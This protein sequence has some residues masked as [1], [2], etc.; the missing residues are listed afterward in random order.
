V[1]NLNTWLFYGCRHRQHDFLFEYFGFFTFVFI[2][3][4]IFREQIRNYQQINVL[5]H[6]FIA[7]SREENYPVSLSA[8][9]KI[10][11]TNT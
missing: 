5:K 3:Y 1:N 11:S 7:A 9:K 10:S 2:L 8:L 4:E 6:L